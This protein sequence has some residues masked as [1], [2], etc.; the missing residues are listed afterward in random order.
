MTLPVSCVPE[1]FFDTTIINGACYPYL[2]VERRQYRF[3]ILNGSQAR[4]Y[5]LQ[6]YYALSNDLGPGHS[7]S[8][9]VDLSKPGPQIIQIGT[10]G[11]FLPAPVALPS[12]PMFRRN[13]PAAVGL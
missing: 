9:E 1:A 5:N 7:P 4:F 10:E 3:R 2:T 12:N 11:G 6:L 8:G 13:Y